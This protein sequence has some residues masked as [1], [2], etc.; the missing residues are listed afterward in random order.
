VVSF[1]GDNH[2]DDVF[3][4][5]TAKGKQRPIKESSWC[6]NQDAGLRSET[7]PICVSVD[8]RVGG[9]RFKPNLTK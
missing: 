4:Q 3:M 6:K 9:M 2:N 1:I 8:W 7:V 5:R